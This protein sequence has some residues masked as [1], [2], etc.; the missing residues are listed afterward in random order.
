MVASIL[1]G[2]AAVIAA[3]LSSALLLFAYLTG[4]VRRSAALAIAAA[5]LTIGAVLA[6]AGSMDGFVF[7]H[8][9]QPIGVFFVLA[10]VINALLTYQASKR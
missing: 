7:G 5:V 8:I 4:R 10:A 3:S 6:L 2:L 1:T 9:A